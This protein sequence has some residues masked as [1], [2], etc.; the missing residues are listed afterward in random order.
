MFIPKDIPVQYYHNI[1]QIRS[2]VVSGQVEQI[3]DRSLGTFCHLEIMHVQGQTI[4]YE[5]NKCQSER[6]ILAQMY[7]TRTYSIIDNLLAFFGENVFK[8]HQ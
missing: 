2:S 5:V 4:S 8:C 7:L 6:F 3:W 1:M